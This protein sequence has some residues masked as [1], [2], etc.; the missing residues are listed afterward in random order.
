[1]HRTFL[2]WR[3]LRSKWSRKR[4]KFKPFVPNQQFTLICSP[5][6]ANTG[7]YAHYVF[8]TLDSDRSGIVSFEVSHLRTSVNERW[9]AQRRRVACTRCDEA[10]E[11]IETKL[12]MPSRVSDV[13][14]LLG[15]LPVI[16]ERRSWRPGVGTEAKRHSAINKNVLRIERLI[17]F[18]QPLECE[19]PVRPF[20]RRSGCR[21]ISLR[22][23]TGRMLRT[24]TARGVQR[25]KLQTKEQF[26]CYPLIY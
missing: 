24:H 8:K 22:A 13:R 21:S 7:L 6:A 25:R 16:R 10:S 3:K 5:F 1:M 20:P 9:A 2:Y 26:I 11:A 12:N 14:K 4:S 19:F 23:P 15:K 18:A 17:L